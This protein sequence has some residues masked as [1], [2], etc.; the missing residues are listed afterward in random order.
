MKNKSQAEVVSDGRISLR[1]DT[2]IAERFEKV[3][4][5][6]RRTKTSLIEEAL[7]VVLPKFEKQHGLKQ[8][9]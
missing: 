6:S 5:A 8:A 7:E 3:V 4:K 1:L 9:A 2:P